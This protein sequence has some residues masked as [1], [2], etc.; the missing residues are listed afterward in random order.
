ML[1]DS[2]KLQDENEWLRTK[3]LREREQLQ[4]SEAKLNRLIN[5]KEID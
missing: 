2:S 5:S 4:C 3:V 1:E